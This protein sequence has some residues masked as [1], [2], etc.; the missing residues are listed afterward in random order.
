MMF[1]AGSGSLSFYVPQSSLSGGMDAY[2][3]RIADPHQRA[4]IS[5]SVEELFV[6]KLFEAGQQPDNA[7]HTAAALARYPSAALAPGGASF[8]HT[9]DKMRDA[10]A[11]GFSALIMLYVAVEVAVYV[12]MPTYLEGYTGSTPWLA[13]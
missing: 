6:R 7:E 13:S 5:A 12:W 10:H 1:G 8:T 3:R 2:R 11:L 9:L 4:E